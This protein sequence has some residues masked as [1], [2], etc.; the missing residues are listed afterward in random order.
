MKNTGRN[1]VPTQSNL[2]KAFRAGEAEIPSGI[3][4]R[5]KPTNSERTLAS[6]FNSTGVDPHDT[7][8]TALDLGTQVFAYEIGMG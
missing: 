6:H 3:G 1:S 8:R 5:V 4:Y 7:L 2:Q